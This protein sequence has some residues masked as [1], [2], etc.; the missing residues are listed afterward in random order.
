MMKAAMM[1]LG[2]V[3]MAEAQSKDGAAAT[4][5]PADCT[6]YNDGCN[7]CSVRNGQIGACTMM[8]C[9]RQGTPFCSVYADGRTCTGP[10]A[11]TS[12]GGGQPEGARCSTT[13]TRGNPHGMPC[14]RGLTCQIT[15]PGMIAA[16]RP[17]SGV[18]TSMDRPIAVDPMPPIA[19]D[20]MPP[21]HPTDPLAPTTQ[22]CPASPTQTCRMLCPPMNCPNGQCAMRTGS[23]CDFTCQSSGDATV[24]VGGTGATAS[25]GACATRLATFRPMPGATAPQCDEN[26]DYMPVQCSGSI[27]SCWCTSPDGSEIPGTRMNTRS[28]QVLDISTCAAA[29]HPEI[30][31]DPGF[32]MPIRQTTAQFGE[33]CA[34]GFCEDPTNCPQCAAGLTCS[35]PRGMMCAGTCYGTCA[36]GH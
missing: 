18:C 11:C 13:A 19:V 15:D 36:K 6:S 3:G 28:G 30:M 20:P 10:D 33:R 21:M 4:A 22:M 14:A 27:G 8:M 35:V 29:Q 2:V 9:F 5:I 1:M 17:N 16:D 23:C 26:G 32:G 24:S 34:Q 25:S 31:V 7:T 12:G